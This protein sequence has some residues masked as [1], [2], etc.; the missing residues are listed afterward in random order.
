LLV[1]ARFEDDGT[2]VSL[3]FEPEAPGRPADR[4]KGVKISIPVPNDGSASRRLRII[5]ATGGVI[6]EPRELLAS[7]YDETLPADY[8]TCAVCYVA[9]LGYLLGDGTDTGSSLDDDC[10]KVPAPAPSV[11]AAG[12]D[13][14][15]QTLR[16]LRDQLMAT[17]AAGRYYAG[18]YKVLSPAIGRAILSRPSVALDIFAAQDAWLDGFAAQLA[19]QGASFAITQKMADDMG[20][21]F[22]KLKQAGTPS[23]ARTLAHEQQR[24]GLDSIAGLTMSQLWQRVN[25]RGGPEACVP[26]STVL[27]LN[28]GRF[29]VESDWETADGRKGSGQAVPLAG[30]SG[31][32]WFFDAAN[33][34]S[35]VKVLDGCGLNQRFWAFAA[36]LTNVQVATTV[37]DAWTGAGKTYENR[38]GTPFAPIQDADAVDACGAAAP[39]GWRPV[40]AGLLPPPSQPVESP[41]APSATAL[42]LRGG[43]FLVTAEWEAGDGQHGS[44]RATALTSDTGTFWFFD[45]A[46]T[47][48]IVKVIDG[49]GL[50]QR[51]WVFAG[52]LTNVRVTLS[53]TDTASGESR[54]YVNPEGRAFQ[55]VQDTGALGGCS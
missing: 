13:Q 18:L 30:D 35:V 24:L 12:A 51:H 53:V 43:R 40:P 3:R 25:E 16:A 6:G 9:L 19:G 28:G 1:A 17:T 34:E 33:V 47:E 37:T 39:A 22:A 29:R 41:C 32:F 14:P 10:G 20:S 11:K 7:A 50:N 42:C 48:V 2:L 23:L 38:Q 46:N 21:I 55:P 52:G 8:A 31:Y 36:G 45:A 26:S 15:V 4:F 44:G 5:G 49:C 27:C 54:V